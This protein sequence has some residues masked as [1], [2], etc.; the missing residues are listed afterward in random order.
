MFPGQDTGHG[1]RIDHVAQALPEGQMD[2]WVLFYRAVLG[3]APEGSVVL[4]DP[5][6][7]VRARAV[8]N[9]SRSLR[10][11]LSLSESRNTATARSVTTYAGAGVS[12]IALATGDIFAVAERM[13]GDGVEILPIPANYYDDLL[14]RFGLEPDYAERL[15]AH[16]ILLDRVGEGTFLHFYTLPF[17]DRFFF[18]IVQRIDGYDLY[19]AP[20]APVRMAALAHARPADLLQMLR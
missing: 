1:F 6:G 18:E 2:S 12:H 19:G 16:N 5:Y 15:A 17:E 4:A 13:A 3:L 7:L 11:P 10:F 8:S 14:A 20:N 9:A